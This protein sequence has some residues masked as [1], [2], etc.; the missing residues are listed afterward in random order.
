M[1]RKHEGCIIWEIV[2]IHTSLHKKCLCFFG[3]NRSVLYKYQYL[4]CLHISR[5]EVRMKVLIYQG[6]GVPLQQLYTNFRI[7][8][9]DAVAYAILL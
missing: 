6:M 4:L 8:I 2:Y 5:V 7:V 1:V 9:G 3:P